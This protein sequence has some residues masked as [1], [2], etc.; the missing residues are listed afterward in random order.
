[1]KVH[2]E[3]IAELQ[4]QIQYP[5]ILVEMDVF[6]KSDLSIMLKDI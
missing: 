4:E 1:M 5:Q 6:S 2:Q 3:E